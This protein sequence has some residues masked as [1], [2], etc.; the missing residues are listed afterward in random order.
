MLSHFSCLYSGSSLEANFS[1]IPP[2]IPDPSLSRIPPLIPIE[3]P[4][5]G[6]TNEGSKSNIKDD[7][8]ADKNKSSNDTTTDN[9]LPTI[10]AHMNDTLLE[11]AQM[12]THEQYSQFKRIKIEPKEDE[13]DCSD[14]GELVIADDTPLPEKTTTND[15]RESD[16]DM[17]DTH[18]IN[19]P[20]ITSKKVLNLLTYI[21][22]MN[23]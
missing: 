15:I 4:N 5:E 1:G 9:F 20:L 2:L 14:Q 18:G 12:K 16:F 8:E 21:I 13:F 11:G 23:L 10:D 17:R 6:Q 19:H 7:S 22:F 3:Y